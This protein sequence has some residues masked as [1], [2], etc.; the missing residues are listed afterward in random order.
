MC[1]D[2]PKIPAAVFLKAFLSHFA[3]P[4]LRYDVGRKPA[5]L[6]FEDDNN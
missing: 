1:F 2:K 4:K 5:E 6:F 3:K